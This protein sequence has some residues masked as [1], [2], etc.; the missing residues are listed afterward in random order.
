MHVT[1]LIAI[2]CLGGEVDIG[3]ERSL[4]RVAPFNSTKRN[5]K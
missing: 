3:Q 2:N 4:G 5:A 1:L